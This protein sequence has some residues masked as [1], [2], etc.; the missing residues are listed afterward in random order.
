MN[1]D[2]SVS[3]ALRIKPLFEKSTIPDRQETYLNFFDFFFDNWYPIVT[4]LSNPM[5]IKQ[6]VVRFQPVVETTW[7][8]SS[9]QK[10]HSLGNSN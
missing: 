10:M 1:K 3:T 2:V 8:N 5:L 7:N 9:V 6:Y 4:Q